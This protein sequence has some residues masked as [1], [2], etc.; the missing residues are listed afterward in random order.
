MMQSS[1][2][3][4]YL[5]SATKKESRYTEFIGNPIGTGFTAAKGDHKFLLNQISNK[6]Y[7]SSTSFNFGPLNTNEKCGFIEVAPANTGNLSQYMN[8]V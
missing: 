7:M 4:A 2:Q 1:I 3:V 6:I 5:S 8:H